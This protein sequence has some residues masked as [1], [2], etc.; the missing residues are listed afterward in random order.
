MVYLKI[1]KWSEIT[2]CANN[3]RFSNTSFRKWYMTLLWVLHQSGPRSSV[4]YQR[5]HVRCLPSQLTHRCILRISNIHNLGTYRLHASAMVIRVFHGCIFCTTTTY[6]S[7]I[8]HTIPCRAT[9]MKPKHIHTPSIY[10]A[11]IANHIRLPPSV[12]GTTERIFEGRFLW[13]VF[14]KKKIG[15]KR[16]LSQS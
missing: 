14:A 4:D 9:M 8:H 1:E 6:H 16:L 13:D 3:W 7:S 10:C 5:Q 11:V 15:G 12:Y 2:N